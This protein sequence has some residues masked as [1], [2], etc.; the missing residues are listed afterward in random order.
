M[1]DLAQRLDS[2]IL[3]TDGF[4]PSSSS[5]WIHSMNIWTLNIATRWNRSNICASMSTSAHRL[6][7]VAYKVTHYQVARYISSNEAFWH[8]FVFLLHN[9]HRPIPQLTVHLETAH[10]IYFTETTA[11]HLVQQS[12]G[13]T[14]T[15]FFKLCEKDDLLRHFC[16][17]YYHHTIIAKATDG[18]EER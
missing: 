11:A 5:C 15:A 18:H 16:S 14:L 10:T 17:L 8:I 4:C 9:R 6:H 3:P 2:N 13:K 7:S 12:N 1:E